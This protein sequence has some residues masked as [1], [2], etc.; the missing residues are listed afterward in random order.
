MFQTLLQT[1]CLQPLMANNEQMGMAF[2][3]LLTINDYGYG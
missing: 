1:L 2:D 3:E